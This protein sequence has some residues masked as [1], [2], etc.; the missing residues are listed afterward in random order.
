MTFT[1]PVGAEK[2]PV[3]GKGA[4]AQDGVGD[5]PEVTQS[6]DTEHLLPSRAPMPFS[7]LPTWRQLAGVPG[8]ATRLGG[9]SLRFPSPRS[10]VVTAFLCARLP[11]KSELLPVC[12]MHL[13]VALGGHLAGSIPGGG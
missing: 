3:N 9:C 2:S 6:S 1:V 7:L 13:L 8:P 12:G 4:E 10:L 5:M 11:S